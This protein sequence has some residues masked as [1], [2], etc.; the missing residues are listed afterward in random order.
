MTRDELLTALARRI[1]AIECS[2]PL[3]VALDGVDAAGKT[4]LAEEL[5]APLEELGRSVIRAS[6]DGFHHP[7][8][9]RYRR[10]AD[11]PAGY[12]HDSFDCQSLRD[13]LLAPLGPT[14]N[15][16][17]RRACFDYRVDAPVAAAEELAPADAVLLFDGVFLLR[18]ELRDHFDLK[19]FVDVSFAVSVERACRRD[20]AQFDSPAAARARYEQRYVP[21]QQLYLGQCRPRALAD[22][23]ISNDDPAVPQITV[24][25]QD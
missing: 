2:H 16:R 21:G 13:L 18:P 12:F 24:V 4:T 9:R 19:I 5:V 15:R 11:S 8:A 14:G 10:G 25:S 7:R 1:T 3:R 6:V 23:I 17:Y 20:A 22:L